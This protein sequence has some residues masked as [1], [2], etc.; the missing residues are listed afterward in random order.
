[1]SHDEVEIKML[2][3]KLYRK[4]DKPEF[5]RL[6]RVDAQGD[7]LLNYPIEVPDSKRTAVWIAPNNVRVEWIKEFADG[8]TL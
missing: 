8:D 3:I 4:P 1:L 2:V 7:M 5:F 6:V